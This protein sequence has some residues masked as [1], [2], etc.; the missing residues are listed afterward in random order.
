MSYAAPDQHNDHDAVRRGPPRPSGPGDPPSR[1]PVRGRRV[2]AAVV[3]A[4]ALLA[5]V[6]VSVQQSGGLPPTPTPTGGAASRPPPGS[7][8]ATAGPDASP[9]PG[10]TPTAAAGAA[11][12]TQEIA[13]IERQVVAI[14]GLQPKLKVA[15]RMLDR[16]SIVAEL[17][18]DFRREN[19]R[20]RL[21]AE[22]DLWERLGYLPAGAD[23]E[24]LVLRLL[25]ASVLGFYQ[26]ETRQM[27]I[28]QRGR[29]GPLE[30]EVVAHEYTHALQDQHFGLGR[31]AINQPGNT[32]AALARR[33]LAEGDA[34]LV[35][36]EWSRVHL[37]PEERA[38]LL[39]GAGDAEQLRLARELPPIILRQTAFPYF[40]GL[41]FVSG[42]QRAGGWRAVNAAYRDPPDSTEQVIHPE[43]YRARERP[44][45]VRL[46]TLARALGRGWSERFRDTLGEVTIQV[47]AAQAGGPTASR[48]AAA[49]W[50]GDRVASYD[51][52]GGD[53]AVVWETVWDTPRDASEFADAAGQVANA[54]S[55]SV[56]VDHDGSARRVRVLLGNDEETLARLRSALGAGG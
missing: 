55:G 27:T 39:R 47:W 51:G 15:N 17:T 46:P 44:L 14:R 26:P 19:P 38:D 2:G 36:G 37:S 49:G 6:A 7:P 32:D 22:A 20:A 43:K 12:I 50:G 1:S 5:L 56:D 41:V 33:A 53:W 31:L 34:T 9:T 21:A 11:A 29:F 48:E 40:D 23:L 42:L 24:V 54:L 4:A 3:A 30:R 18:K 28:L 10:V 45:V 35:G 16:S 13:R 25:G 52:P 8:T